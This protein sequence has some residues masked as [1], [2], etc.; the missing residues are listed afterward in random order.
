MS[1]GNKARLETDVSYIHPG[2]ANGHVLLVLPGILV[3]IQVDR[4]KGHATEVRLCRRNF[5]PNP[6]LD[7]EVLLQQQLTAALP[8]HEVSPTAWY[9]MQDL[10]EVVRLEG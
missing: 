10:Q 6:L 8:L 2:D 5:I 1:R 4:H 3:Q 9:T 7:R